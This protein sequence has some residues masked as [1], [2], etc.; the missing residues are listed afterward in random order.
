MK[1]ANIL[2][3]NEGDARLL[4]F[5][6]AKLLT[7]GEASE[8]ELTR[9]GGRALTPDYASPEQ[10]AGNTVTTASD[11]YSLG[12][13][14]YEL[15]TGERPYKLKRDTRSSLEDA[16]LGAG[17]V[18]PSQTAKDKKLSR[19]LKGDLDS[20]A[21]K[22]LGK[23][24]HERYST[25]DAFAQDIE[26][27]LHGEPVL[28]QPESAWYRAGKFVKRNKLAAGS[29]A[30]IVAALGIGLGVALWQAHIAR[31][32]TRTAQTV[33]TFLLDI[34]RANSNAHA[35]PVK[36]RQTTAR[37]LLD[38]GAKKI[39]GALNDAAEAKLS[40][41]ETLFRLYL[42]LGLD[43]QAVAL[44]RRR[45]ALA[46][47][48]YGPVHPEVARAL[49]DL[50]SGATESSFANEVPSL[51]KE[52]GG[53]LDR[54]RDAQSRI[55]ADYYLAMGGASFQTDLASSEDLAARSVKLYRE[56]PPSPDLVS[57]LNFLGQVQKQRQE[58]PAAIVSLSEAVSIANSVQGEAR[59]N[60]P[61]IYSNLGESQRYVLDLSG[62]EKSMRQSVE[63]ARA[64]EG[65]EHRDVLQTSYRLG[66]F[67]AQTSRPAEGLAL[68]KETV[69]LAVRTKGPEELFHTPMV[70]RGYGVSLLEY[71]RLE[72]GLVPL[73]QSIDVPRR[74][75]RSG[76]RAFAN[77]LEVATVGEIELGHYRQ[78]EAMLE[79]ASAI[80]SR[81]GDS[82]S[83]GQLNDALLA[84][85]K[86]LVATGK[87]EEA[88]RTL[89]AF[90]VKPDADG[91]LTYP[92]LSVSVAQAD[93]E[94]EQNRPEEAIR[95]ARQVQ[96]RIDQSGLR[97][98]FKR[99]TAQAA[100]QEGK[101]LLLTQRAAEALPL[102]QRAVQLG[103][104]V[105]D[106]SRSPNLADSQIALG[107]CLIDLGRRDEARALLAQAKAIHA[108]HK[109]LGEQF[110]KP[111]R[112]LEARLASRN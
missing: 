11:V 32:Q 3:T 4:D 31:I 52:A 22:A 53:I 21:L 70:R 86:L 1:P 112:E 19:A 10:I 105:Y 76:T 74:A 111:L 51:L 77:R 35:D 101:G 33:R 67:L 25:A 96:S 94:L 71:G 68:L 6:I 69:D 13:I 81:L 107:I 2:V 72:E 28:A 97:A 73:A 75:K 89:L 63:V 47:S 84:R 82:P 61:A 106:T 56:H 14:L 104:E 49:I 60:L 100:L 102:L 7:E 91:R 12:V 30:A 38:M 62:A 57:A 40:V 87:A 16:I 15:L 80:R 55:R 109:D 90:P 5:G 41:L 44:G 18:R 99:W 23:E 9:I 39:D 92:W 46:K 65:A 45:I 66:V 98:Y 58:Y 42:D 24:P 29:A 20:I 103:P 79:E 59:G 83:S 27:Y 108:A 54:N 26:R 43:D 36:A 48:V 95:H 88:A 17:A 78:A 34:F 37:E 93:V 50:A 110:R 64:L 8:T 85:A